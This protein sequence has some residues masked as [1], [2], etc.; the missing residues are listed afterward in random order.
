MPVSVLCNNVAMP[1][2]RIA[3]QQAVL[4]GI[5]PRPGSEAWEVSICQ[6]Q[7]RD[8]YIVKIEGPEGFAWERAF[9]GVHEKTPQFIEQEV[10]RATH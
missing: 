4:P 10:W 5:G 3:I 2:R 9:F 1:D 7:S 8:E 6:S